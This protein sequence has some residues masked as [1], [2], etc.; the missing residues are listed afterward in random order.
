VEGKDKLLHLKWDYICKH[1]GYKKVEKNIKTNVKKK[2]W[3][4]S[5]DSRH[6]KNFKMACFL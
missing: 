3:Y 1:A 6:A 4:Y 5:K 2:D